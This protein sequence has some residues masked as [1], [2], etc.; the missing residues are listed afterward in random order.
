MENQ[1]QQPQVSSIPQPTSSAGGS[2]KIP[3]ALLIA[4]SLALI[5]VGVFAFYQN[6]EIGKI[7]SENEAL[8]VESEE[9]KDKADGLI[10]ENKYFE[11]QIS[12]CKS[13]LLYK[14]PERAEEVFTEEELADARAESRD[15]R[16]VGDIRQIQLALEIYFDR[17]RAYPQ[18]STWAEDI[19]EDRI[20]FRV[21]R[22]P[23]TEESYTYCQLSG[24]KSYH[25]GVELEGESRALESDKDDVS[26]CL[27]GTDPVYDVGP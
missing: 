21:P 22:D 11:N 13:L 6:M 26:V 27:D 7:K 1:E 16:R 12:E 23:L 24:G 2:N 3:S 5:G 4:V 17:H 8:R 25:L 18:T 14:Y 9:N 19:V 15:A 10:I 20:I